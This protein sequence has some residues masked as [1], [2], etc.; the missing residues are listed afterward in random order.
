[1]PWHGCPPAPARP[2]TGD[3]SPTNSL[4]IS[5][6]GRSQSRH[7]YGKRAY[8][9]EVKL[10]LDL[11]LG[12]APGLEALAEW[13][14]RSR[15]GVAERGVRPRRCQSPRTGLL[16]HEADSRVLYAGTRDAADQDD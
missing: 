1:M 11:V 15:H 7:A 3:G 16:G 13:L 12:F 9:K 6:T 14:N 2:T 5:V 4:T 8:G 10:S